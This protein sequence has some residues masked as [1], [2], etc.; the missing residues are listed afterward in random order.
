MAT[1]KVVGDVVVITSALKLD[2]LLMVQKYRPEALTIMGGD[3]GKTPVFR[4]EARSGCPGSVSLYGITF[5]SAGYSD[6]G[7]ATV[8]LPLSVPDGADVKDYVADKYGAA[9]ANLS[10]LEGTVPAVLT[11]VNTERTALKS[12]IT[13]E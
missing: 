7:L 8:V 11:A 1:I 2:D 6:S 9:I 4:I 10:K 12:A 5:G 13:I 3:D